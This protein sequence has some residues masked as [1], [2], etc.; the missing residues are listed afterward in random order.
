MPA[1]SAVGA[2]Q[3]HTHPTSR[4]WVCCVSF[5]GWCGG[6]SE[7]A[8]GLAGGLPPTLFPQGQDWREQADSQRILPRDEI[9]ER[10]RAGH[11]TISCRGM[12]GETGPAEG[13]ELAFT[14][15]EIVN[16]AD[17][18]PSPGAPVSPFL[19]GNGHPVLLSPR[20]TKIRRAALGAFCPREQATSPRTPAAPLAP[21]KDGV[22]NASLCRRQAP[23]PEPA[24]RLL[25]LSPQSK[26]NAALAPCSWGGRAVILRPKAQAGQLSTSHTRTFSLKIGRFSHTT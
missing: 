19:M 4:G 16:V 7:T 3:T 17:A 10:V 1:T 26:R 20:Q 21:R 5:Q 13:T 6:R 22:T 8:A 14:K 12:A 23:A 18:F 15:Y 25:P 11:A 24:A 2:G 9:H